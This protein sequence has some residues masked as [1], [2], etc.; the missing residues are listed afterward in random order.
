[1][2]QKCKIRVGNVYQEYQRKMQD[3]ET[4]RNVKGGPMIE[5]YYA[6][7]CGAGAYIFG[8]RKEFEAPTE[9]ERKIVIDRLF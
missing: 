5:P 9:S 6:V 3:L 2:C 4:L 7:G 1:M 8:R